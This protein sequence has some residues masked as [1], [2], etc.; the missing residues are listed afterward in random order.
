[1]FYILN[2]NPH[3]HLNN[4]QAF[5]GCGPL[6]VSPFKGIVSLFQVVSGLAIAIFCSIVFL[7]KGCAN[8]WIDYS[9]K[10]MIDVMLGW[11]HLAYSILNMLT[12]GIASC[13]VQ[14]LGSVTA[15]CF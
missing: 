11:L 4:L 13:V 1:M 2:L 9:V 3:K 10:G 14:S 5:G 6:V 12:L 15:C 8:D 7:V